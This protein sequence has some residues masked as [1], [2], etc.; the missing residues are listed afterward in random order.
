MSRAGEDELIRRFFAPLAGPAA[1]GLADDAALFVPPPG[2]ELVLT[3]DAL[4]AGI[5]FFPDDPPASIGRKALGV[6]LS[7]LAAKGSD[8]R[9][10]SCSPSRCPRA[11]AEASFGA[12]CDG[13]GAIARDHACPLFGGDTVRTPGPLTLSITA[14][15]SVP[16]GRMVRRTSARAGEIVCVTG[17]IGDAHLGLLLSPPSAP[18]GPAR[19]SGGEIAFLVDRYRHPQPRTV[20]VPILGDAARARDGRVGRPRAA[21]C[22]K[23]SQSS[24]I[25][26]ELD[27][28]AVPLSAAARAVLALRPDLFDAPRVGRGR[29]TRSSS[30]SPPER[31]RAVREAAAAGGHGGLAHRTH[32]ARARSASR[33]AGAAGARREARS[34]SHF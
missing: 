24:R 13:L 2:R 19:L 10:V 27:L 4:V 31:V 12:F 22:R 17:T 3:A 9:R 33:R 14:F 21:T 25:G 29:F 20:L 16:A 15:G 34:F 28:D 11:G 6:N 30:P 7:D 23:C 5:H 18:T 8:A 26:G 1:L 32:D